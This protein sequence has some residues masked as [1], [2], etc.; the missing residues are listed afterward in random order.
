LFARKFI[1]TKYRG[2]RLTKLRDLGPFV[3]FYAAE[4]RTG[5][6]FDAFSSCEPASTSHQVPGRLSFENTLESK[7]AGFRRPFDRLTID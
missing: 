7:R 1:G 5:F 2:T 3:G 6:L 4:R